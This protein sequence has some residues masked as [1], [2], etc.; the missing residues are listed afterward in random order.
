MG[1]VN[2]LLDTNAVIF[3]L[4]GGLPQPDGVFRAFTPSESAFL[5]GIFDV[6]PQCSIVTQIEL[7]AKSNPGGQEA[8]KIKTILRNSVIFEIGQ[9][10]VE[11][12]IRVR[13]DHRLK[14][15]DAL[16]AAT[17]LVQDLALISGNFHDFGKV[18]GLK[19]I[20]LFALPV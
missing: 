1:T 17:A 3:Y 19:F 13:R 6:A 7:M 2:Y 9:D 15:P 18:L 10:L 14:M 4:K 8:T 11:E 20:N 5:D 16:I 12:T